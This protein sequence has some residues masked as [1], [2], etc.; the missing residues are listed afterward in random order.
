MEFGVNIFTAEKLYSQQG[1][2]RG[3]FLIHKSMEKYLEGGDDH[4][5]PVYMEMFEFVLA[6][7]T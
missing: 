4:S 7:L 6:A 3:S 2:H 1:T 5:E